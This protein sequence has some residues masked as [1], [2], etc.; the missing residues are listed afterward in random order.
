MLDFEFLCFFKE[1]SISIVKLNVH[2]IEFKYL[3]P[4][5]TH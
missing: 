1:L 5:I 3:V 2:D 4:L